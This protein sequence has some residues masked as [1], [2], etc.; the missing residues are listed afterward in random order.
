MSAIVEL[1]ELYEYTIFPFK[2]VLIPVILQASIFQ[3][4]PSHIFTKM[5]NRCERVAA[6]LLPKSVLWK[7]FAKST[8]S[9]KCLLLKTHLNG[10]R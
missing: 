1:V 2:V 7:L 4:C 10:V 3:K 8:A 6:S 9:V 5:V